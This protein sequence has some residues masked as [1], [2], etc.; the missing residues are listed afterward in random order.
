M[1]KAEFI[2]LVKFLLLYMAIRFGIH[3]FTILYIKL[4]S[5]VCLYN[6]AILVTKLNQECR[7][8]YAL[9]PIRISSLTTSCQAY[10]SPK[11]VLWITIYQTV[12][13]Q[14]DTHR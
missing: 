7:D 3:S 13:A 14:L 5:T 10:N 1:K 4:L 9:T 6:I 12:I 2:V 11:L 8:Y